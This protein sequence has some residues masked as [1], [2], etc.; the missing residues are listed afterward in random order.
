MTS[1]LG[2]RTVLKTGLAA[3]ALA[4]VPAVGQA[5]GRNGAAA[6]N[7][8][9]AHER[10]IVGDG[11][12]HRADA[13]QEMLDELAEAG[14]GTAVLPPGRYVLEKTV[15]IPSHVHLV[16]Q[17]AGTVL[18]G[19]RPEGVNGYALVS[20]AGIVTAEGY[21]GAHDFSIRDLAIDTPRTNGIVLVHA[22]NAYF[23]N[24]V[25]LDAHHHHFDIAGSKNVVCENLFL[26][27]RSG[28]APF[29]IDG[30]PFNNNTWDGETN[31]QP[32]RDGTENDGIFL[33]RSV[34]RPTNRSNHGIHL[35]RQGG[36]NIFIDQVLIEHL[37]N[38][39]Y[40]DPDCRREDV[41]ISNVT[42]R[43]MSER[44]IS[45][46]PTEERDR[47]V[48]LQNVNL[49]GIQGDRMVSHHGCD[50]LTVQN[51]RSDERP[52]DRSEHVVL[53]DVSSARLD[54]LELNCRGGAALT[55]RRC[56]NS[57]LSHVTARNVAA[58]LRLEACGNIQR[59]Q[60][61]ELGSDDEPVEPRIEEE[62]G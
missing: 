12:T 19:D 51:L 52:S 8:L 42:I 36:R 21:D 3:S 6:T 56:R 17:G 5:V 4:M 16:G 2:R 34:I 44:G 7:V 45:F 47:R 22:R 13:I 43:D 41:H 23:S 24:V 20:N 54:N 35:H 33:S 14:G 49:V 29:Q 38:G 28:T 25:G 59:S 32:I 26:T 15:L 11:I 61:M 31:V 62:A 55:L 27:G 39:I 30:S 46:R 18:T 50:G 58:S 1:P 10:G 53:E 37:E 48:T 60:L 57:F 9:S 40:R